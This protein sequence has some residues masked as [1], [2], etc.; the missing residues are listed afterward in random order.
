[1]QRY[2][3]VYSNPSTQ[4][5]FERFLA[6]LPKNA[7]DEILEAVESLALNP[8][9]FGVTKV[10]PPLIVYNQ[11]AHY[12]VRIRDHRVLYDIDDARKKVFIHAI[13]SRNEKT[14]R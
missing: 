10:Q 13:R 1:M 2:R 3:I 4:K 14:Y 8:R 9:P 5:H 12:R 11:I 6:D 7:Q